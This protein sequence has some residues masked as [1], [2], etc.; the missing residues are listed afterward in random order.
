L[1][2][3][4]VDRERRARA[5]REGGRSERVWPIDRLLVRR[6]T[7]FLAAGGSLVYLALEGAGYDV[8]VRQQFA[9]VLWSLVA[10]G[11]AIGVLPRS[12]PGQLAL[13]PGIALAGLF[14]WT[15]LSFTWTESDERTM[16]EVARVATYAGIVVLA[17][18]GLNK[19]TFSAAAAGVSVAAAVIATLAVASRLAPESFPSALDVVGSFERSDRLSFPLDYWNAVGAWGAMT[20]AIGLAWSAHARWQVARALSLSIVPVAGLA[21]Y[22]SYSRA[23]IIASAVAIV[24]VLA[25]SRNRWTALVHGLAAAGGTALVVAVARSQP[26]IA[27]ATGGEGARD[28]VLALV[29]AAALGA[30]AVFLT[31]MLKADDTRLSRRTANWAV[32]GFILVL[33]VLVVAGGGG[34]ISQTWD[35]F[36]N[37]D[38]PATGD[39]PTER[40]TSGGGNRNDIWTS[41]I[42]AFE[43]EPVTGIGAGTFE[44]WWLETSGDPEYVRDAHS[45]YFEE[46]AELGLP[47][48][49]LLLTF[50]GG[51]AALAF[52]ARTALR[53]RNDLGA[54]VAMMS[55]AAVFLV[56]AGVDWMW[57][58]TA[59]GAL[60]IG[61]LAIAAAGSFERQPRRVRRGQ[62]GRRWVRPVILAGA[63]LFAAIQ[64]PGLVSNQRVRS[65][66]NASAGGDLAAAETLARD[67][68]K[69]EPW[70]A[71]PQNQLSLVLSQEG[72][73]ADARD[74][75]GSAVEK[76]PTNWRWPLVLAPLEEA[77]GDHAA[78]L[79]TFRSGRKLAPFS[80]AYSPFSI[81][82]Q[83]VYSPAE[84]EAISARQEA[85]AAAR[86]ADE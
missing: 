26:Q 45:L 48:L 47:G 79:K 73:L 5:Y 17:A 63:L 11:F 2:S 24:A 4:T 38:A 8:V 60:G 86:A 19:H 57:E 35:E 25:L 58:E 9:L 67:A 42:D 78:A 76:E 46:M 84:L 51:L 40:L 66:Q 14:A 28:V 44:Y 55:A 71:T 15:V 31:W 49:L 56:S 83:L 75:I 36:Q 16:V 3:T 12:S 33:L 77:L 52:R 13:V 65:S 70:A 37:Q 82:G 7:V 62:L 68:V 50:L 43:Q 59:L 72:Q 85:R 21:V 69:A 1:E 64:V 6:G 23:G 18:S 53:R 74:A 61:G 20:V 80:V 22:L 27:E 39:D 10:L 30:G 41:A 54:C 81:Y 29:A 32:P 34:K